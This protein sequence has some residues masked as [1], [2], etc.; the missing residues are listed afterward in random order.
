MNDKNRSEKQK[1]ETPKVLAIQLR[2]QEAVLA[3]CK[4]AG[5]G[6]ASVFGCRGVAGIGTCHQTGS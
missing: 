4:I 2:P 6:G 1:Y 5:S 3:N